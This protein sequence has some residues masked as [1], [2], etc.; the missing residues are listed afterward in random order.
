MRYKWSEQLKSGVRADF[1]YFLENLPS[2]FFYP[3]RE[4]V[5]FDKL[6]KGLGRGLLIIK[7]PVMN[8]S[9]AMQ[10]YH[11]RKYGIRTLI[12]SSRIFTPTRLSN[13]FVQSHFNERFP[14]VFPH[15]IVVN[16]RISFDNIQKQTKTIKLYCL[17]DQN[18]SVEEK[19]GMHQRPLR[20][21]LV[22]Q[23]KKEIED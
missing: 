20:I 22:L 21:T 9:G 13:Q 18:Y 12:L 10:I 11:A 2:D 6:F 7:G 16:D 8:K 14:I 17:G 4:N 3:Y 19:P 1:Q 5:G 15:S 23:K